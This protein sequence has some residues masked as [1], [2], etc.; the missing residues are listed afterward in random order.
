MY[1]KIIPFVALAT[2]LAHTLPA[3][4]AEPLFTDE[5]AAAFFGASP[6]LATESRKYAKEALEEYNGK[7]FAEAYAKLVVSKYFSNL[8]KFGKNIEPEIRAKLLASPELLDDFVSVLSPEDDAVK[9]YDILANIAKSSPEKFAKYPKLAI[10]VAVVF[11]A[12]PPKDWPHGQVSEKL[13]PRKLPDPVARFNQIADMRER[14]KFLLPTEKMSIEE[15]KYLVPSTATED[16]A[17]WAQKSVSVSLSNLPKLYPSIAY[18]HGR[19]NRK[20]FDWTGEDYRLKTIKAKG[21]ICV[22]QAYYTMEVAKARGVPAFI[23]SARAATASTRGW[24][25]CSAPGRGIFRLA[26]TKTR[27]S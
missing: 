10:A 5:S 8:A 12:P 9:V 2:A 24:R 16:D 25:I 6:N 19:L 14:G 20:Q 7:K 15:L 11:D 13:L 21:G 3:Q 17:Q 22:D 27:A 26:D 18:D 4:Q 23:L 1:E